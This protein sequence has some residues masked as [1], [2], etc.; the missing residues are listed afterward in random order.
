MAE[1]CGHARR[2]LVAGGW[3]L[4][5]L[6]ALGGCG[7]AG[8]SKPLRIGFMICNSV[9]ETRARFAPLAAHLGE[10]L[11]RRVEPV[12][13]D[14]ADFDEAV[15]AG[16]FDLIHTN[17]YLYVWFRETYG[18][19]VVAGEARG[20]DGAY[21]SGSVI[22]GRESPAR[23]LADLKGKRFVFGPAF[24][25]TAYLSPYWLLLEAG[26]D[27]EKDLGY[28]AFPAGSFKHEKAIYAVVNGAFDAG[29]GPA[30]DLEVME[31]EGKLLPEDYRV[32]V[33]GPLVP[34]CVF[35]AAS[36]LPESTLRDV[37][38]ALF[39]LTPDTVAAVD[40]EVRKVLK[41]A[42]VDGFVPLEEREFDVVRDM[43]RRCNL[44]PFEKY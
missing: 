8:G 20:K 6:A 24:A 7:E 33:R 11:G 31:A 29:A 39:A 28:Y 21:S 41:S 1:V 12:W 27:P 25:P 13:L 42:L 22:V 32:L 44:P 30:L 2:R 37:R 17:S 18:F 38:K 26:V 14:T 10:Q 5:F 23:S 36:R 15:R 34:Y 35:S 9:E 19:R 4:V 16:R 40:G 43:A 3:T